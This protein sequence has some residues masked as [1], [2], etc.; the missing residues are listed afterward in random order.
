MAWFRLTLFIVVALGW[1]LTLADTRTPLATDLRNLSFAPIVER[2]GPA[3]VSIVNFELSPD[4]NPLLADPVLRQLVPGSGMERS[5]AVS[6]LGSGVV[7]DAEKGLIVTNH[8]VVTHADRLLVHF[9]DGRKLDARVLGSDEPTDLAL[10][11]VEP[12]GLTSMPLGDSD[13]LAVGD[14]VLAVGNPFGLGSTV[15]SGVISALGRSG[16]GIE[17][18]EDF[19]QTDA[20]INPGNSGGAL[21]NL[22]GE[23]I[24]I[25]TAAL[26]PSGST[27]G[28]GFAIPINMAKEIVAQIARFGNVE[29]GRLGIQLQELTPELGRYFKVPAGHGVIVTEVEPGSASDIAG[30]EP[31]D[32]VTAVDGIPVIK[33]PELTNRVGLLRVGMSVTLTIYRHGSERSVPVTVAAPRIQRFSVDREIPKLAGVAFAQSTVKPKKDEQQAIL[34]L[35][36]DSASPAWEAGLRPG[37]LVSEVNR[38]PVSTKVD[39]LSTGEGALLLTV[40]RDD[41]PLFIVIE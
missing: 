29:R 21:V 3:V 30:I 5:L 6:S 31:A 41:S 27:V 8:H 28:I 22:A 36:V 34:V 14:V 40:R 17:G 13:K 24:G 26:A 9:S 32:I 25:N 10:L 4:E 11:A 20:S 33:G 23:L 35:G 16:L 18:F 15:T 37:D 2:I 1:S 38:K 19:I 39:V 12:K 7:V